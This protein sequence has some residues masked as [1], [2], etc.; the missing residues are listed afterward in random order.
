MDSFI[1]LLLEIVSVIEDGKD[2]EN[3]RASWTKMNVLR[4]M[5][6][7]LG[8]ICSRRKTALK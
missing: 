2:D 7:L 5:N 6:V 1:G 3:L 4:K 8:K